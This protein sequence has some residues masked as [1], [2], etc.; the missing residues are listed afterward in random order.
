MLQLA[1]AASRLPQLSDSVKVCGSTLI[2]VIV[3]GAV[4]GLAR[5]TTCATLIVPTATLPKLRLAGEKVASGAVDVPDPDRLTAWGLPVALSA[6]VS[7]PVRVPD[8]VGANVTLIVQ[9]APARTEAPQVL[10]WAKSPL[11]PMLVTLNV[12]LPVFDRVTA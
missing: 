3:R 2:L 6:I 9:C 7:V 11:A 5:V 8:I 10:V 12:A 4:P 1:P